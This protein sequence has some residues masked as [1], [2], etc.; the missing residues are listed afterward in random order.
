MNTPE[1]PYLQDPS[2]TSAEGEE[3]L[4]EP[5]ATNADNAA[6]PAFI[7][8][9]IT[10]IGPNKFLLHFE[11]ED[12]RKKVTREVP[13]NI[14]GSLLSLQPWTPQMTLKEVKFDQNPFWIQLHGLP[15]DMMT[16]KNATEVF[17]RLG[18]ILKI[19]NPQVN[20]KFLRTFYRARLVINTSRPFV[21]SFWLPRRDLP[22][23]AYP[24]MDYK[25]LLKDKHDTLTMWS[26]WS[27]CMRSTQRLS[28]W[29]VS[30]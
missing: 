18:H 5:A 22:H 8:K 11:D 21:T 15:L 23:E 20:G 30:K 25:H 2:P 28:N 16:I 24:A 26:G 19:E 6:K 4:L 3:V 14:M 17:S 10:D 27:C 12:S 7:G 29:M 1:P 13:W 9:I